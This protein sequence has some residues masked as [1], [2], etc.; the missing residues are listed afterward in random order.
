M[1]IVCLGAGNVGTQLAK[2]LAAEDHDLTVID[3]EKEKLSAM[4]SLILVAE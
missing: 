1:R 2:S 3:T 4:S